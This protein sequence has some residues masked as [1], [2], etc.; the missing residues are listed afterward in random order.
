MVG[1]SNEYSKLLYPQFMKKIK[2]I[3][4]RDSNYKALYDNLLIALRDIS[5]GF[6]VEE[7]N[8]VDN[9][10]EYD[11]SSIPAIFLDDE[12]VLQKNNHLAGSE[13]IK[14][15]IEEK[16]HRPIQVKN[17]LVPI[18]FSDVSKNALQYALDLAML[19]NAQLKVVHIMHPHFETTNPAIIDSIDKIVQMREADL[20]SFCNELPFINMEQIVTKE[21]VKKEIFIG[22]AADKL[23]S[24]SSSKD[25]DLIVMG[26]T[27]EGDVVKKLLGGVAVGVAQ[28]AHCPVWLIPDNCKFNGLNKIIYASNYE[29]G[30]KITLKH[31]F[32][33]ANQFDAKVQLV[34]VT[35][36]KH[37]L[38]PKLESIMLDHIFKA[39]LSNGKVN[40]KHL[41]SSKV[42]EGL[43]RY[44]NEHNCDLIVMVTKHRSFVQQLF[45]KSKTAEVIRHSK[46][47]ILVMHID[48]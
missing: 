6:E 40:L 32:D 17:I 19:L 41:Q 3:G 23:I 38:D 46:L 48:D 34:H 42:W 26:T 16:L 36:P 45:H 8:D 28:K 35:E 2:I 25:V 37:K 47:P 30:D 11:I 21:M 5:Q 33:F 1:Y 44:A 22:F 27:G 4:V 24:L 9:I 14:N 12:M 43:Y 29:S 31:I 10:L 15:L 7:I 20:E 18:D 39:R 13:E